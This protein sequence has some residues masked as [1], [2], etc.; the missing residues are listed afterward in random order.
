MSTEAQPQPVQ[1][2]PNIPG[3][4][5]QIIDILTRDISMTRVQA[6]GLIQAIMTLDALAKQA[7]QTAQAAQDVIDEAGSEFEK[8]PC[9]AD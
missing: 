7:E 8:E 6:Q 3:E 4:A 9:H 5:I 1:L 2:N